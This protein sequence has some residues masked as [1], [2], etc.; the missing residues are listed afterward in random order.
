MPIDTQSLRRVEQRSTSEVALVPAPVGGAKRITWLDSARGAAVVAVVLLH[1]SIGH[2]YMLDHSSRYTVPVWDRVNQVVSVVRMPL[3]FV[4]SGM[5]AANKITRGFARG[6]SLLTAVSNYYLYLVWLLVYGALMLAAGDRPVPFR[7]ASFGDY[8]QQIIVP[9]THLW[10]VFFLGAYILLLT[11]LRRVPPAIVVLAAA[12]LHLWTAMTYT[13]ESPLWTR[14]LQFGL[15]FV[16]GVHG[17]D[18]LLWVAR[19]HW[20]TVFTCGCSVVLYLAVTLRTI[21]SLEPADLPRAILLMLLYLSATL[22]AIGLAGLLARVPWYRRLGTWVGRRT[23]GIY[24]IH[25]PVIVVVNWAV[26]GP[27]AWLPAA[28]RNSF[29]FDIAW[30]LLLTAVVVASCVGLQSALKRIGLGFLFALPQPIADR[31]RPRG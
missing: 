4:V 19:Q 2:F 13:V 29:A 14:G 27:L 21:M 12:A 3:L 23:L 17:R 28:T 16:V 8:A 11:A 7:F 20:L 26:A 22:A 31:L 18:V 25:I 24:V 9:G 30:P 10:F 1:V 15:F 6:T 5:L